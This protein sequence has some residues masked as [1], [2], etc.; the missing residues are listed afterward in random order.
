MRPR[1]DSPNSV[2]PEVNSALTSGRKKAK[3]PSSSKVFRGDLES[4]ALVSLAHAALND[5]AGGK[6]NRRQIAPTVSDHCLN[7]F[8]SLLLAGKTRPAL[9]FTLM[10]SR[11]GADYRTIAEDLFAAAARRLGDRYACDKLSAPEVN[12]GSATLTRTHVAFCSM[13]EGPRPTLEACAVFGSFVDQAHTLGLSFA[14]E[15]FRR[16]GWNV[17]Y[18]P[19]TNPDAFFAAVKA[20]KPDI[21]GLTAAF[22]RDIEIL[23]DVI[24]RLRTLKP[25]PRIIVGGNAPNRGRLNPDAVVS[26]LDMGLLAGHRL[27]GYPPT[28]AR[29]S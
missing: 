25:G 9:N 7:A 23:Q 17:H 24:G 18:M 15:Y 11:R 26:R 6:S 16:N 13:L 21:V 5:L 29:R 1:A 2:E 20:E 4:E 14:A 10:Y 28:L 3:R 19:G 27:L 8:C 12:I 22:D